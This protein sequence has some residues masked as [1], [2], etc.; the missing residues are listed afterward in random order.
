MANLKLKN[1][2]NWCWRFYWFTL[3]ESLL[4][5]L[6]KVKALIRYTSNKNL[7]WLNNIKKSKNLEIKFG[8]IKV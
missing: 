1:T 5:D 7:G 2:Y 4:A 6:Y 8:D 3:D